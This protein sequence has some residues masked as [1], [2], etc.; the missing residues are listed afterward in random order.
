MMRRY[1]TRS[2]CSVLLWSLIT[3]SVT[4]NPVVNV[5][6]WGGEIPQTVIH[7]FETTTGIQVNFSTYD[8]NETMYAKLKANQHGIY[9]VILPSSYFVERMREQGM[10]TRLDQ[11][12]LNPIKHLDRLFA[13]NDYDPHNAYSVPLT[14][15]ATGIFYNRDQIKQP[16]VSWRQLWDPRFMNQLLLLDDAREVF[17]MALM[18]LGYSPNDVNTQHITQAYQALLALMPNIKLF[19]SEGIQ[20]LLIDE[21]VVTGMAW[22]GDAYKARAE[23]KAVEFLYPAEGFVIWVDCLAIP[24][25]APHLN[26]AYAFIQFLLRPD[27]AKQLGLSQGHAITNAAGRALL[28]EGIRNDPMIYPPKAILAHGYIQRYPGEKVITLYNDYWQQLKMA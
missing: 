28:P 1:C 15:G 2:I 10:L 16:P 12:R 24:E 4:A 20:A 5:Y 14:W 11:K 22:N 19:S 13:N 27:V 26:E 17:A 9:D 18:R 7:Q 3:S 8:S 6:V 23:N 21:D 25:N